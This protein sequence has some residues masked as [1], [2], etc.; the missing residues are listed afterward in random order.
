MVFIPPGMVLLFS[1]VIWHIVLELNMNWGSGQEADRLAKP[2]IC[3]LSHVTKKNG[4]YANISLSV[5]PR[6]TAVHR[7]Q[8]VS[9]SD[10]GPAPGHDDNAFL[11]CQPVP[12]LFTEVSRIPAVSRSDGGPAPGPIHDASLKCQPHQSSEGLIDTDP[13]QTRLHTGMMTLTSN[14]MELDKYSECSDPI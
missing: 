3:Q 11:K 4:V 8:A 12:P 9:R 6:F 14:Q 2:T 13:Q 5:Y 10:E 7:I 1:L